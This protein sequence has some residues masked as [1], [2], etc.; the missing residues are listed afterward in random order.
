MK[1]L[2]VWTHRRKSC[3]G[4]AASFRSCLDDGYPPELDMDISTFYL[5]KRYLTL[6]RQIST[7]FFTVLVMLLSLSHHFPLESQIIDFQL[8]FFT[9]PACPQIDNIL[10]KNTPLM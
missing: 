5:L 9:S 8:C 3:S 6:P 4:K 7:E 2:R 1:D 10:T